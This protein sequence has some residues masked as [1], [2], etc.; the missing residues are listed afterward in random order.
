M[1]QSDALRDGQSQ[2]GAT[3]PEG[4]VGLEELLPDAR[5]NTTAVVLH[6]D[7]AA[8]LPSLQVQPDRTPLVDGGDGVEQEV[9]EEAAELPT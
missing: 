1:F 8:L 9:Q 2:P 5:R 4:H 7:R 3:G 6:G